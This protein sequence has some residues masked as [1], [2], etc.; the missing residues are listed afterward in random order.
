MRRPLAWQEGA[1]LPDP[2]T[3]RADQL[4]SRRPR[5][6]RSPTCRPVAWS[7]RWRKPVALEVAR[8]YA[9]LEVVYQS[10]FVDTA[11]GSSLDNVV[12]LLGI[13]RVQ[14]GR[15]AGE[16]EFTRAPGSR[17]DDHHPGRDADHHR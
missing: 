10:G 1:G 11:T 8:L 17:G 7:A 16:M 2:G 9:Q 14:G 4:L 5:S 15:A 3:L 13:E 12:A 6:P